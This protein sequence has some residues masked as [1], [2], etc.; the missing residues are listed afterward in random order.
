MSSITCQLTTMLFFS[1]LLLAVTIG[2]SYKYTCQ[3][4]YHLSASRNE[5]ATAVPISFLPLH[6]PHTIP[7]TVPTPFPT[8]TLS[9]YHSLPS[10]CPHTIPYTV[11]ILFPTSTLSPNHS[12]PLHP[13]L[14][15]YH[16]TVP[17]HSVHVPSINIPVD[18][19]HV[20]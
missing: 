14:S 1:F 2:Y 9:P 15:P 13:H 5:P 4:R 3:H 20:Y 10:H 17:I 7:Y 16:S 11:P 19:I 8:S 18:S 12:L 6:C